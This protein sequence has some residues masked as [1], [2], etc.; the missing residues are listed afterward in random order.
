MHV[1]SPSATAADHSHCQADLEQSARA[2][3]AQLGLRLTDQ[4]LMVLRVLASSHHALGAYE[5]R[6][7]LN[8]SLAKPLPPAAIYRSLEFWQQTGLVHRIGGLDRFAV[9]FNGDDHH[10][11][12]VVC[13]DKCFVVKELCDHRLGFD[14]ATTLEP[15]G[16][17]QPSS[18]Q[19]EVI[20]TCS[21]CAG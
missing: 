7:Q 13:C 18:R 9:C 17:A 15:L 19:I 6:E 4:R 21:G 12:M 20:A 10:V 11:H 5:L 3:C 1:P 2:K 16:Y 14:L 8:A